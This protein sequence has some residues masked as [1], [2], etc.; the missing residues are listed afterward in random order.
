V[1]D[2]KGPT[3]LGRLDVGGR[4]VYTAFL[5]FT[6]GGLL[7]AALLHADGMGTSA[8]T[9]AAWW[10]GDE[11]QM[12]YPKSYR[13]LLELSHFHLFTEP[14]SFL[15]VAHLYQLGGDPLQRRII[16]TSITLLAMAVQL[17]LPWAVT[18]ASAA[19]AVL[20]VPCHAALL[21]GI[22]YMSLRAAWDMWWG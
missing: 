5:A 18:Y 2:F 3:P 1:R 22:L 21:G 14:V 12:T 11:A 8:A 7:S 16:V 13:Q 15:V 9:A 20:L 10:R 6:A 17:A 19:F 4:L